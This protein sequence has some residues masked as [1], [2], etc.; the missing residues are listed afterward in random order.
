MAFPGG[1]GVEFVLWSA[2]NFSR[3]GTEKARAINQSKISILD[4][5]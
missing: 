3:G 2:M 5:F 1:V 4:Q